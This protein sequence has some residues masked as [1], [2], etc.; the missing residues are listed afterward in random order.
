[1][2]RADQTEGQVSDWLVWDEFVDSDTEFF[3]SKAT[4]LRVER[5]GVQL[6]DE[7]A[8]T[9]AQDL[10]MWGKFRADELFDSVQI[11]SPRFA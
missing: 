8:S 11:N 10:A 1:M 2:S 3:T 6:N 5:R 9:T 7:L 4:E